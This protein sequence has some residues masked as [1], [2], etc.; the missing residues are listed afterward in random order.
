MDRE[1]QHFQANQSHPGCYHFNKASLI[2]MHLHF[3][4]TALWKRQWH[5]YTICRECPLGFGAGMSQ[6]WERCPE[7][8]RE[9]NIFFLC[10]LRNSRVLE[11]SP[12]VRTLHGHMLHSTQGYGVLLLFIK[13]AFIYFPVF[14]SRLREI[15]WEC[16]A[17]LLFLQ[18][19]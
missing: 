6:T 10:E 8:C 14:L 11:S 13:F 1:V 18:S 5:N 7:H 17:K 16:D 3:C 19:F 4:S 9:E 12:S 2:L 15:H